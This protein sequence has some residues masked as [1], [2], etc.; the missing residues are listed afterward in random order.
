MA[1]CVKVD[2]IKARLFSWF[3]KTG[4]GSADLDTNPLFGKV[5]DLQNMLSFFGGHEKP[6][7]RD[8]CYYFLCKNFY[9]YL[10]RNHIYHLWFPIFLGGFGIGTINLELLNKKFQGEYYVPTYAL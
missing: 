3:K 6:S 10:P 7:F 8:C 2:L 5:R 9:K 4:L 1:N